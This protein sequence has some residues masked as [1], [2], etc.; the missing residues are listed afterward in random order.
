MFKE[1]EYSDQIV[2]DQELKPA[3][4]HHTVFLLINHNQHKVGWKGTARVK[5][6]IKHGAKQELIFASQ[7][8]LQAAQ[9]EM[10]PTNFLLPI[11]RRISSPV[12]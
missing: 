12:F 1:S 10:K 7:C 5:S 4:N 6:L 3:P 8:W 11:I 9:R 2:T